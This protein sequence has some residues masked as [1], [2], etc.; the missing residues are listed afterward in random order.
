VRSESAQPSGSLSSSADPEEQPAN[1]GS[2][3]DDDELNEDGDDRD[4]DDHDDDE[5][6]DDGGDDI[7]GDEV[8]YEDQENDSIGTDG[9]QNVGRGDARNRGSN[10]QDLDSENDRSL[11]EIEFDE[12]SEDDAGI[13]EGGT[14][15]SRAALTESRLTMRQRAMQ[16][17]DTGNELAKLSSPVNRKRKVP[18]ELTKDEAM[19]IN[20]Q[21]RARLRNLVHEKRNKEKRAAMVDKVLRGVTSKRKKLSQANEALAAEVGSR[22]NNN[23]ARAGFVRYVNG[24]AGSLVCVAPG[25]ELPAALKYPS[26]SVRY[27]PRCERDPRTGKRIL[28]FTG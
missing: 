5:D 2:L 1:V 3:N 6:G 4:D 10:S 13:D 22:L 14:K 27:P 15:S 25:D 18:D 8:D 12:F 11:K 28:S 20:K 9:K 23:E 24:R 7:N 21:Q 17:E 19:D 16:G 26:L